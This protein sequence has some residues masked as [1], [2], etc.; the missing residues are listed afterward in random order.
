ME[1]RKIQMQHFFFLPHSFSGSRQT[2][3]MANEI[4]V[5]FTT[6]FSAVLSVLAIAARKSWQ[7]LASVNIVIHHFYSTE[8]RCSAPITY[9]LLI[10]KSNNLLTPAGKL[11]VIQNIA[12]T[13]VGHSCSFSGVRPNQERYEEII[14][15]LSDENTYLLG[16]TFLRN[17]FLAYICLKVLTQYT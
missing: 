1:K 12:L 11:S 15:L 13:H 9:W 10:N 6:F 16:L 3:C 4:L 17:T 5:I 14:L 7:G 2:S 8:D